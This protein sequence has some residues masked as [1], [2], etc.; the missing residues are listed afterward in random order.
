MKEIRFSDIFFSSLLTFSLI[1][2]LYYIAERLALVP[3]FYLHY[4]SE[5][6]ITPLGSFSVAESLIFMIIVLEIGWISAQII[7]WALIR[8]QKII[9]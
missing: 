3:I 7:Y 1:T 9:W 6:Q 4:E 8:R 2:L 5:N